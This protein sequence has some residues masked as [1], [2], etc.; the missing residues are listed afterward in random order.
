MIVPANTFVAT[1]EAVTQAGGVPV[2]VDVGEDDYNLDVPAVEAAVGPATRFV[3]P[4]AP[5]RPDG[6]H[7]APAGARRRDGLTIV[8][9]A[10]QAHGAE[11]DGLRAG[12]AGRAAAFSFYPGKN[13][14]AIGDAGAL[15]T[16]D[17]DARGRR[18]RAARAR[19][20]GRSTCTTSSGCTARLDT[21][22]ALVLAAQAPAARRVERRPARRSPRST[23]TASRASATSRS[24]R[25]PEGSEPVVAPLRRPHRGPGGARPL[26]ADARHRHRAPL[27][28]A[29]A[30]LPG[31]RLA[32]PRP[33]RLPGGR[34]P[35]RRAALAADLPGHG[36][37]AGA[38]GRRP[39]P[40]VLR[41]WL[42][43][44]PTTRRTG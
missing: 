27:P 18:A 15:V 29:A 24:R 31:V 25:V 41:R 26:P 1:F 44:R 17:D 33:R 2:L 30:P 36:A 20:A 11:R 7:A 43:S 6:R 5:L 21:I 40:R 9:D 38:G 32:R 12:T 37:G 28:A 19:P 8:E 16:D 39:R 34:G 4:G 22:Q 13:L 3:L 10:C 42:T 35:R 14:G 23:A